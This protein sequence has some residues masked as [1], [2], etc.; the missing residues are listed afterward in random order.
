MNAALTYLVAQD[1]VSTSRF[2]LHVHQDRLGLSGHS[3]G[4]GASVL[5]AARNPAVTDEVRTATA[6]HASD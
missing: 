3:M 6:H 2:Y 4:G 5:A 1:A